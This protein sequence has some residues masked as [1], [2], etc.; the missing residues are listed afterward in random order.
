MGIGVSYLLG[1]LIVPFDE[2]NEATDDDI[3]ETRRDIQHYIIGLTSLSVFLFALV[4]AYYPAKPPKPPCVNSS[5]PRTDF[6]QGWSGVLR[7][8]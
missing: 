3:E 5:V 4:L 7:N 1:P 8:K 2:D 6:T